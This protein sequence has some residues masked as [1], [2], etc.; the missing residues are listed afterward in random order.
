MSFLAMFS[1]E[2]MHSENA[3]RIRSSV[4][5]SQRSPNLVHPMPTTATLSVIPWLAIV[6]RSGIQKM[7]LP[8]VVVHATG[9]EQAAECE[10]D[11]CSDAQPFGF[12]VG[13]L[14]GAPATTVDVHD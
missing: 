10:R 8:E 13:D 1:V 6:L 11:P 4:E 5:V 14:D 3:S 12:G 7:R 2:S 9:S